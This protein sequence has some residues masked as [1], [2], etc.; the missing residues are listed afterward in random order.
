[1]L[2]YAILMDQS[3]IIILLRHDI[4]LL[5]FLLIFSRLM[6][7]E[8]LF[9]HSLPTKEHRT[10]NHVIFI[11]NISYIYAIFRNKLI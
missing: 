6:Q 5:L 2:Y 4:V 11:K 9:E 3:E 1:M 8:D 7:I 10:F